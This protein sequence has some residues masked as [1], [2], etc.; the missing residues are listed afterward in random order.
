MKTFFFLIASIISFATTAQVTKVSI[1]ASGLT[2]SM[3]SNS[4]NKSLKSIDFVDNVKPNIK[5]STFEITFKPGAKVDFEQLKKKVE[6]AGFTVAN[7][8]AAINFNNIQAKNSQPVKVGD[9]T[10]Y[11]LNAKDQHLNGT[12]EVRIVDK[13]FVS[14]KESKKITLVTTAPAKGVYNV[15]I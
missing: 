15:T 6:D 9:K 11:I 10:F 5:T 14:G 7:F 4:I 13:G 3:C 12:T 1:Q 2:C 8:V